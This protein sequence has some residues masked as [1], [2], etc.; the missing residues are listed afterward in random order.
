M[1]S[2][3]YYIMQLN[4]GLGNQFF[5][6]AFSRN[7]CLTHNADLYLDRIIPDQTPARPFTLQNVGGPF[8]E[9]RKPKGLLSFARKRYMK[10]LRQ[11]SNLVNED[12]RIFDPR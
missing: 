2:E 10:R 3:R 8:Q 4:G 9:L 1:K 5:Q 7:L 11:N 6:Y 12:S